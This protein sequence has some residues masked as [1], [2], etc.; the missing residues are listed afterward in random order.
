M[1]STTINVRIVR[2]TNETLDVV[3]LELAP[4]DGSSLPGFSAG[5]H[6]DVEVQPGVVRQYSLCNDSKEQHRYIIGVLRDPS[7]RGGSIAVHDKL[8]E[9]QIIR[10]SPPRNHFPLVHHARRSLLFAGGIGVT[11]ILC[12]AERLARIG[13]DFDMHYSSRSEERTAFVERIQTSAY[14]ERV[15]FH[16]DNGPADQALN[17]KETLSAEPDDCHLYVCGPGG[18]IDFVIN[19]AKSMGWCE[20]RIH[21]ELFAA[22]PVDTSAN[23][24]FEVQVASSGKVYV[25][26]AEETIT[27]V[28]AE[29][30]VEVWTSCEQGICGSCMTRVLEGTPD[31]RDQVLSDAERNEESWITPCCSRSLSKRLVL[32]I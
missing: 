9:G 12:M 19:T 22:E 31:H 10:I 4:V 5:S 6:I 23:E 16:F 28:L 1:D 14:R 29:D 27:S 7:S 24:S 15:K 21:F 11:P 8:H 2:K 18:F 30:G 17:L 13:S 32:D 25:V 3:T 20:D 26:S